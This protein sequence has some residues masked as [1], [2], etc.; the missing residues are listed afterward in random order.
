MVSEEKQIIFYF[1]L[2]ISLFFLV[3][4]LLVI[5]L[6]LINQKK[7]LVY[8]SSILKINSK[9]EN[10]M[11]VSQ[12]QVQENTFQNISRE[13]HDNIGQKLTLAKLHLNAIAFASK[14]Q[15]NPLH[16]VV[17]MISESLNDLRDISRSL[18][19]E[20]IMNSGLIKA[21]EHE[22]LLISKTSHFQI[23]LNI[24][25]DAQYLKAEDELVIFRIIQEALT[26]VIK[27]A[28]AKTVFINLIYTL[29]ELIVSMKDDGKGF[30][31]FQVEQTNGLN[32]MKNRTDFLKGQFIMDSKPGD[33]TKITIIIPY[34]I[35]THV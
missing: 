28:D 26:N 2:L 5:N 22:V 16:E 9:H 32:N 8:E 27:H 10:E 14:N 25:G 29:S 11:L 1:I 4:V 7:K 13:I 33:G 17:A 19:S 6:L 21:L 12:I 20:V 30:D 31:T 34:Q 35:T 3:L 15:S 24:E 18:S 23:T